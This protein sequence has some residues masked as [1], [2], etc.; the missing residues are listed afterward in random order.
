[1]IKIKD[2][3]DDNAFECLKINSELKICWG[4]SCLVIFDAMLRCSFI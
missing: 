1:M 2:K 3:D 4:L